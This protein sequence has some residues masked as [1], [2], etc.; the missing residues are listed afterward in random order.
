MF[1]LAG[2][3]YTRVCVSI[4]AYIFLCIYCYLYHIK[5]SKNFVVSL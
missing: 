1:A 4:N 3:N 5:E 2:Q